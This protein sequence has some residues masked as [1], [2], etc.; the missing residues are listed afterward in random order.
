MTQTEIQT[1]DAIAQEL[2][3]AQRVLTSI[4]DLECEK[5]LKQSIYGLATATIGSAWFALIKMTNQARKEL[6]EED[7]EFD[8]QE[9]AIDALIQAQQPPHEPE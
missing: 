9:A 6:A 5:S 4:L 2:A 7:A 3:G 1:L 8:R